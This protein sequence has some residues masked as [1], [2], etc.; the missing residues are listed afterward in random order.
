MTGC[1]FQKILC[2]LCLFSL[3]YCFFLRNSFADRHD[4]VKA[5]DCFPNIPLIGQFCQED[6]K[7]LCLSGRKAYSLSH[8]QADFILVEIFSIYCPI[9][10]KHA[11]KFNRLHKM[12]Q[13]DS[14]VSKNMKMIGIGAGNNDREIAYFRKYFNISFPLIPDSDYKIHKALKETRAPFIAIIDKRSKPYKILTILDFN[15]EPEI[16]LKDIRTQLLKCKPVN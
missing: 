14:L 12:V 15:K 16:L 6:K 13:E 2:F 5:G 4:T 10:Q 8:I 9:C 1:R 11:D 7:Y 3:L